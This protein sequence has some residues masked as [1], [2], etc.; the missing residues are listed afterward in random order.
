MQKFI[1]LQDKS[2]Y[3][4]IILIDTKHAEVVDMMGL[5][6]IPYIQECLN[7]SPKCLHMTFIASTTLARK[8]TADVIICAFHK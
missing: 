6:P 8:V 3:I 4:G 1:L 7:K 5:S 2:N